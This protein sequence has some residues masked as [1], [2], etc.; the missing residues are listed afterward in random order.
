MAYLLSTPERR[1]A[2]HEHLIQTRDILAARGHCKHH[3]EDIDRHVCLMGARNIALW[4]SASHPDAYF[5]RTVTT[6]EFVEAL[7]FE[8]EDILA[9]N[10]VLWNNA[11]ETTEAAVLARLDRAI[12]RT[13]PSPAPDTSERELAL[14]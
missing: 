7:D 9:R 5:N 2:L 11:P 12:A 4:G 13:A 10:L 8:A 3:L 6:Q 1:E 14:V